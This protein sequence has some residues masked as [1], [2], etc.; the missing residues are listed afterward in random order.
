MSLPGHVNAVKRHLDKAEQALREGDT[1]KY[2]HEKKWAKLALDK[3]RQEAGK[4]T[5]KQIMARS[6]EAYQMIKYGY[7]GL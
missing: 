4:L 2:D 5:D 1:R 3:M 6:Q 7:K